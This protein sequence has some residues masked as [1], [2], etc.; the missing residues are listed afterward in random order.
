M[1]KEDEKVNWWER[2]MPFSSSLCGCLP[3][4]R[5]NEIDLGVAEVVEKEREPAATWQHL[6]DPS[7]FKG[8]FARDEDERMMM[9]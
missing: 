5:E 6:I 1:R 3:R 2:A 7:Q 8:G 4:G 9:S